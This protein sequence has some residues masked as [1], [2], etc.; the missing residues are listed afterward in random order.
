MVSN[1]LFLSFDD[2]PPYE[3]HGHKLKISQW[4]INGYNM[5][6]SAPKTSY[7]LNYEHVE[8]IA[9]KQF[10]AWQRISRNQKT[11]CHYETKDEG[12]RIEKEEFKWLFLQNIN[13]AQLT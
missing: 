3:K 13:K 6:L 9:P 12:T 2:K 4:P 5:F 1:S 11:A 10:K 7:E 8:G